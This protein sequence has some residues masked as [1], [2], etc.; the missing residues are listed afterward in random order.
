MRLREW[1]LLRFD[2]LGRDY[3]CLCGS[4]N[5]PPPKGHAGE[6]VDGRCAPAPTHSRTLVAIPTEWVAAA[7]LA[8]LSAAGGRKEP[9][10]A[11]GRSPVQDGSYSSRCRSGEILAPTP[12][13]M[14]QVARAFRTTAA[15]GARRRAGWARR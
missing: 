8:E 3:P 9:P 12:P 4:G 14:S 6:S 15:R 11:V 1:P 5:H 7:A 10:F 2:N 13:L